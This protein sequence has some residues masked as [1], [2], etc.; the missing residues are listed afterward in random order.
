MIG[1]YKIEN[2]VNSKV[3]IGQS[4]DIENRWKCHISYLSRGIH[5]NKHLQSAWD[6][7]GKENFVFSVIEECDIE[8]LNKR[9]IYWINNFDSYKNG[10]NLTLGGDGG[11]TIEPETVEKIYDLYN[12]G[13]IAVEISEQLNLYIKT[14]YKYLKIGTETGLCN[15]DTKKDMFKLHSK[16]IVCLNTK[17]IFNSINEAENEYNIVGIYECCTHRVNYCGKDNNGDELFWMYYDEYKTISEDEIE[18]YV[19][20]LKM[21]YDYKIVCINTREIFKDYVEANKFAGLSNKQSITNCCLGKT[22]RSGKNKETGEYYTWAY[23]RDYISMTD[24]E[25]Q[26][27][28][29]NAQLS[30]NEKSV[31]CLNNLKVFHSPKFAL[32][33]CNNTSVD[34]IKMC[35]RKRIKTAGEDKITHE[36]LKWMYLEDYIKEFG[37]VTKIA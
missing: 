22:R 2:K 12:N 37:E 35:C 20:E 11:K 29:L 25:K 24:K 9:E 10:Y 16:K 26:E 15:Y 33:W 36:R 17:R 34:L 21:K 7:Y 28:I 13:F 3:Y 23:Y 4:I 5:N 6:K 19:N 27:K 31:I 32:E 14:V 8:N 18:T 1:I 30:Y